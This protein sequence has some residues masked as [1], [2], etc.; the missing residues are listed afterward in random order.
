MLNS[1][2]YLELMRYIENLKNEPFIDCI[3]VCTLCTNPWLHERMKRKRIRYNGWIC[4]IR[5]L[6]WLHYTKKNSFRFISF[7]KETLRKIQF[8]RGNECWRKKENFS[9]I[10]S[11]VVENLDGECTKFC[12]N[13]PNNQPISKCCNENISSRIQFLWNDWWFWKF[14]EAINVWVFSGFNSKKLIIIICSPFKR[15]IIYLLM[16]NEHFCWLLTTWTGFIDKGVIP[17]R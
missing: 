5:W 16:G 8:L 6:S 7:V 15:S 17:H 12:L 9:T 3:A 2:S 11:C 14:Y 13:A 4:G 10:F 1:F